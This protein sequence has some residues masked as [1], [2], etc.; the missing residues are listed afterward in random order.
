MARKRRRIPRTTLDEALDR[1]AALVERVREEVEASRAFSCAGCEA[2][3]CR[4]GR[5]AM[6]VTR[7]E[8]EAILERM[9]ADPELRRLSA[10]LLDRLTATADRLLDEEEELPT[11]DCPFLGEDNRCLVHGRGQPLG[12][13]TFMPG[14]GGGCEVREDEMVDAFE[15]LMEIQAAW[16]G[17]EERDGELLPIAV[18]DAL[19]DR[20]SG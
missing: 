3:C 7:V 1:L 6:L 20:E 4:V 9:N 2:H 12:C 19:E 10:R 14:A 11:Y 8:T 15:E 17:E 16:L 18:R 5:N 13:V